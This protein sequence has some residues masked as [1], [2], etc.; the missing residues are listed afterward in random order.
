M[1]KKHY[2]KPVCEILEVINSGI[3]AG[4][5]PFESDNSAPIV[6]P[7]SGKPFEQDNYMPWLKDISEN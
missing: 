2:E 6:I 7:N 5:K 3:I 1:K 4:S